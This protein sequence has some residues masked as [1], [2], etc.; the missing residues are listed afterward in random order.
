[1][2]I[3]SEEFVMKFPSTVTIASTDLRKSIFRF[4]IAHPL[5]EMIHFPFLLFFSIFASRNN[6]SRLV[7]IELVVHHDIIFG[8]KWHS[9]VQIANE[10]K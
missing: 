10:K 1:M 8:N 4:H 7:S 9:R 6:Y 5:W 3:Q 2:R